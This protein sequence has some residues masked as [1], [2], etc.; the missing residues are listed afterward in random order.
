MFRSPSGR[1]FL[2]FPNYDNFPFEEYDGDPLYEDCRSKWDFYNL[3][4]ERYEY[5]ASLSSDIDWVKIKESKEMDELQDELYPDLKNMSDVEIDQN[6]DSYMRE[7]QEIANKIEKNIKDGKL[8]GSLTE[9]LRKYNQGKLKLNAKFDNPVVNTAKD[10]G[11]SVATDLAISAAV[12]AAAKAIETVALGSMIMFNL[13]RGGF[14][15]HKK[16]KKRK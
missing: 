11:K 7:R 1:E 9:N 5:N 14:K 16:H 2:D 13:C 10:I 4:R 3:E 8:K 15:K 12:Y 6:H